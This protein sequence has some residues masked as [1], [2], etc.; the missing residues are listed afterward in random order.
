MEKHSQFPRDQIDD[1]EIINDFVALGFMLNDA[2]VYLT[3]LRHGPIKPV[4]ISDITGV[5]RSRVYDSLKRLEK[6]QYVEKEPFDRGPLYKASD[7]HAILMSI[8]KEFR[9][10][11]GIN[12]V[13]AP[14][15]HKFKRLSASQIAMLKR[16]KV[17]YQNNNYYENV[18]MCNEILRRYHCNLATVGQCKLLKRWNILL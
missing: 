9:E 6:K 12:F 10:K 7:P 18:A 8:R 3:L 5:D 14:E 17:D 13:D 11:T 1:E 2:R 15:N 16:N 4:K